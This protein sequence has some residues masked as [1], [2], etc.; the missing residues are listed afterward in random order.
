MYL[1][2][3]QPLIQTRNK[4]LC[5]HAVFY[6]TRKPQSEFIRGDYIA[7]NRFADPRGLQEHK[8]SATM[9]S[10][11][12]TS[13]GETPL[14]IRPPQR[15]ISGY[16]WWFIHIALEIYLLWSHQLLAFS[17][18]SVGFEPLSIDRTEWRLFRLFLSKTFHSWGNFLL[19]IKILKWTVQSQV[20]R[21]QVYGA[22]L[23]IS[24]TFIKMSVIVRTNHK[25]TIV[26]GIRSVYPSLDI[27]LSLSREEEYMYIYF[28]SI[29]FKNIIKK[30]VKKMSG[31]SNM[32]RINSI[33]IIIK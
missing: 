21:T 28:R 19:Y 1:H 26:Y 27:Y 15:G 4:G 12:T 9:K 16:Y 8:Q 2:I 33:I 30:I 25:W 29:C 5:R 6:S 20:T 18:W 24:V 17:K 7:W 32:C 14:S 3:P 10:N 22:F 31:I 23:H 13:T 11:L